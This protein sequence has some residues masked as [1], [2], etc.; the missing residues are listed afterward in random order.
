MNNETEQQLITIYEDEA[1]V[2]FQTGDGLDAIVQRAKNAVL[3]FEHDMSTETGRKRTA[4]L[5]YRIARLKTSLDDMGKGLVADWKTKVKLVDGNR[6]TMRKEL[7]LLKS[8][9]RQPLDDWEQQEKLR[10]E[11]IQTTIR[12][13]HDLAVFTDRASLEE[14][15]ERLETARAQSFDD[16]YDEFEQQARQTCAHVIENLEIMI[17]GE[18][19]R[20]ELD[21]LRKEK[22]ERERQEEEKARINAKI[23]D[24]LLAIAALSPS[25]RIDEGLNPDLHRL[26]EDLEKAQSI[27]INQSWLEFEDRAMLIKERVI[28]ELE[29]LIKMHEDRLAQEEKARQEKM[30]IDVER[31]AKEQAEKRI[32]EEKAAAAAKVKEADEARKKAL[33]Q[34]KHSELKARQ[35]RDE[36]MALKAAQAAEAKLTAEKARNEERQRIED[37]ARKQH[38]KAMKN[39]R[40]VA[41]VRREVTASIKPLVKNS[42]AMAKDIVEAMDAGKI[43]HVSINYNEI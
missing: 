31:R 7:D 12:A 32:A 25:G 39:K 8:K 15:E 18:K 13:I 30:R 26:R 33:E 9:A 40:H 4:S 11:N 42:D 34:A 6:R 16:V 37:D 19:N 35:H 22:E 21:K 41:K 38:E 24:N 1:L 20:I 28:D 5:A 2:A 36:A 27:P 23:E 17:Q 14:L 3:D 43:A 10:V 29:E